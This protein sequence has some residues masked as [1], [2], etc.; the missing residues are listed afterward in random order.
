MSSLYEKKKESSFFDEKTK[1]LSDNLNEFE[2]ESMSSI[3]SQLHKGFISHLAPNG[4]NLLLSRNFFD[5]K[6]RVIYDDELRY[7]VLIYTSRGDLIQ[8]IKLE[9]GTVFSGIL[10]DDRV[11]LVLDNGTYCIYNPF[12]KELNP[13]I[14]EIPLKISFGLDANGRMIEFVKMNDDA[15]MI[16]AA[17]K[18][19]HFVINL[20]SPIRSSLHYDSDFDSISK[21]QVHFLFDSAKKCYVFYI[22]CLNRGLLY[23][24]ARLNE[25]KEDL[26]IRE[27]SQI[28][29]QIS[30]VMFIS[31]SPK[32]RTLA[33]FTKDLKLHVFDVS[34]LVKQ[35]T[36][37][38]ELNEIEAR[39]V[40]GIEWI[41]D[42]GVVLCCLK[43][44]LFFSRERTT[45]L[46]LEFLSDIHVPDSTFF[47]T[48]SEIDGLRVIAIDSKGKAKNVI[49]RKNCRYYS[50][51]RSVISC[52]PGFLLYKN[53]KANKKQ[54]PPEEYIYDDKKTMRQGVEELIK[55]AFFEL[56]EKKQ[57]KLIEAASYGK[58][59]L[60]QNYTNKDCIA[61]ICR[62]MKL[63]FNMRK[64]AGKSITYKQFTNL[65]ARNQSKLV[66]SM[67]NAGQ[68]QF[69]F[70]LLTNMATLKDSK[71][72]SEVFKKWAESLM[73]SNLTEEKV[74]E[75]IDATFSYLLGVNRNIPSHVLID[76]AF[77]AE[78]KSKK[79]IVDKVL[80]KDIPSLDKVTLYLKMKEYE[81]AIAT[82]L[83][84]FDSDIIYLVFSHM[85]DMSEP[86]YRNAELSKLVSDR[87][88]EMT[89]FK[90]LCLA[91]AISSKE[92]L[93]NIVE[94]DVSG[95][96]NINPKTLLNLA[97]TLIGNEQFENANTLIFAISNLKMKMPPFKKSDRL[98]QLISMLFESGIKELSRD[99]P[100][101]KDAPLK[102]SQFIMRLNLAAAMDRVIQAKPDQY[103]TKAANDAELLKK[104]AISSNVDKAVFFA[105]LKAMMSY[106]PAGQL[107]SAVQF[108]KD[109]KKS[110]SLLQIY[111]VIAQKEEGL[112]I[113]PK[114][115]A[116]FRY[117]E[118]Y[119]FCLKRY[120]QFYAAQLAIGK[121]KQ[122]DYEQALAMVEIKSQRE[123]LEALAHGIWK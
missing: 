120:R 22:A 75:K 78:S 33:V 71:M 1:A 86:K 10:S 123:E 19:L 6:S 89:H 57:K 100:P 107:D 105:R 84:C 13:K 36:F 38:S 121:R 77:V 122:A 109:A 90:R 56:Y 44:L 8:K 102:N 9:D 55:A 111:H 115:L 81:K 70:F 7:G 83:A 85:L 60:D 94:Y 48:C 21:N 108:I 103:S 95:K 50:L 14:I 42:S 40:T 45:P 17:N 82:G 69:A 64:Q 87:F 99:E 2:F 104:A 35:L 118:A 91:R 76:V 18:S 27:K 23:F 112:K 67:L 25:K 117:E 43:R 92:Y 68:F 80:E 74:V 3:S 58:I 15:L 59:F 54:N 97:L 66:Q 29:T 110:A 101:P 53:Y 72:L 114:V 51:I 41:K 46:R 39:M 11:I 119:E 5:R 116:L 4:G 30:N 26:I 106:L 47:I 93:D 12:E 63:I 73:N 37:S 49:I 24:E 62:N 98:V 16:M 113:L 61:D 96:T 79:K 52:S 32:N 31:T 34:N 20:D 88:V 28:L 65:V